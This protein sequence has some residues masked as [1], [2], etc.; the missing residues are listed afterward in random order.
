[1]D[2]TNCVSFDHA[3]YTITLRSLCCFLLRVPYTSNYKERDTIIASSR[4]LV[5][6]FAYPLIEEAKAPFETWFMKKYWSREIGQETIELFL[7]TLE[8]KMTE[9]SYLL[10]PLIRY[11]LDDIA[12]FADREQTVTRDRHATGEENTSFNENQTGEN[13]TSFE[14]ASIGYRIP[15]GDVNIFD[16]SRANEASTDNQSTTGNTTTSRDNT[17]GKDRN[18]TENVVETR[19]GDKTYM[20]I[21]NEHANYFERFNTQLRK[22]FSPLFMKVY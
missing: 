10:N 19:T 20:S 15:Q 2:R 21:L 9:A 4:P 17:T 8:S 12:V 6:Y 7:E 1:M 22:L 5:F 3:K 13:E 18:D 11:Q 14:D 16:T